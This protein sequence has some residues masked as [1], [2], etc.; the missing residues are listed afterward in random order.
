[1]N[2]CVAQ[3]LAQAEIADLFQVHLKTVEKLCLPSAK[4]RALAATG[5]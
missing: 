4:W 3:E 2:A 5:G 1:V